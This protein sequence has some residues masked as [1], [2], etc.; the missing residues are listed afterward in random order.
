MLLLKSVVTSTSHELSSPGCD[1]MVIK[2]SS[3]CTYNLSNCISFIRYLCMLEGL[4]DYVFR[5]FFIG[6]GN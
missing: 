2:F 6:G 3:T 1:H 5:L 4:V